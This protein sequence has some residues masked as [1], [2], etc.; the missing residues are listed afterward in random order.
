MNNRRGFIKRAAIATAGVSVLPSLDF[1][2]PS[3]KEGHLLPHNPFKRKKLKIGFIGLG[4]SGFQHLANLLGCREVEVVALCDPNLDALRK[5]SALLIGNG[6]KLPAMFC[7]GDAGYNELLALPE[8]E[9]VVIAAP[10]KMHYRIGLDALRAHKHVACELVMGTTVQEHWDIVNASALSGRQYMSLNASCFRRDLMAVQQLVSAGAFGAIQQ[11][12]SGSFYDYKA[13]QWE[14]LS[15]RNPMRYEGYGLGTLSRLVNK[16][17][18]NR[19]LTVSTQKALDQ[20]YAYPRAGKKGYAEQIVFK[21]GR[22]TVSQVKTSSEQTIL[23]QHGQNME[24]KFSVGYH[25]QGEEG[26]WMDVNQSIF[27][28]R[29]HAGGSWEPSQPVLQQYEHPLWQQNTKKRSAESL[30]LNAFVDSLLRK[31]GCPISLAESASWSVFPLLAQE[32]AA[33]GG[34][35]IPFPDFSGKC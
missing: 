31:T 14:K 11:A 29:R 8:V 20:E 34:V 5:S 33:R 30:L 7:G 27:L 23:V 18:E 35:E 21:K 13:A 15:R 32:S 10:E 25:L 1:R 16:G 17:S 2:L 24:E 3:L 28:A 26:A 9:A 22:L 12:K 6:R 4:D 19:L